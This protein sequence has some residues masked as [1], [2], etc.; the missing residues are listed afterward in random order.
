MSIEQVKAFMEE[1]KTNSSLQEKLGALP[2]DDVE[3]AISQ[4]ITIANEAG[5]KFSKESFTEYNTLKEA[6]LSDTQLEQV[7]GG[8][9]VVFMFSANN[10][11][12]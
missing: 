12:S 5:Y 4:A 8:S 3:V 10:L 6:E 11:W 1:V 9:C 7:A 2:K